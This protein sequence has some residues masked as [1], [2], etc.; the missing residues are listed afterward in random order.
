MSVLVTGGA[1]FIGSHLADELVARGKEVVILDD[2]SAGKKENVNKKARLAIK[3]IVR[4]DI[5]G[6]FNGVDTVFHLAADPLVKESAENP[7]NSFDINVVGT[8]RVLEAC[9]KNDVE[10][11]VFTS[12]ST[13]Y[14]DAKT[15]PTPETALLEPIS[16]YAASKLANEAFVSSYCHTYGMNG[17]SLRYANIFGPRGT[18]GVMKDFFIKLKKDGKKLEILGDGN[19]DKSY[20]FVDDC[21]KASLLAS[22][23]NSR[24]YDVFNVGS[25]EKVKVKRLAEMLCEE[26]GVSPEFVFTGGRRGWV[27]DVPVML[28]DTKKIRSLGWK[29]KTNFREGVK[30]YLA[31]LKTNG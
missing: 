17:V 18:H 26:L 7:G 30:K 29:E 27:G 16:N 22:E 3:N 9:R 21:V 23:K 2:L 28:L 11:I 6:I 24:A 31:W 4:G 25:S 12:T 1:G 20:L 19:Q 15:I 8:F 13:V 5:N 14:G 10:K